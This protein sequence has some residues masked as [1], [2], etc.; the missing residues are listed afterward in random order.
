MTDQLTSNSNDMA[1]EFQR[2]LNA[3]GGDKGLMAAFYAGY[4]IA[5]RGSHETFEQPMLTVRSRGPLGPNDVIVD[6]T[7]LVKHV[8]FRMS[9]KIPADANAQ[10]AAT[11]KREPLFGESIKAEL[12]RV[13]GLV[14]HW[15]EET[16]RLTRERD[17]ARRDCLNFKMHGN[18][19]GAPE[20][21]SLKALEQQC[22]CLC[23][24]DRKPGRHHSLSCPLHIESGGEP[25]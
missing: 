22:T 21:G 20:S 4:M 6:A 24:F 19:A 1:T 9:L 8:T 11:E 12:Q 25:R 7:E 3:K 13:Y 23:P 16:Q 5:I 14:N 2:W 15:Y 10:K 17:E 18:I